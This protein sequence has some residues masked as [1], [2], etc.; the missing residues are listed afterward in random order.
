MPETHL[1]TSPFP[2]IVRKF[3]IAVGVM[4]MSELLL[5]FS[6]LQH[7]MFLNFASSWFDPSL[8]AA[9]LWPPLLFQS[10]KKA[11][12]KKI[13]LPPSPSKLLVIGNL[14]QL[15]SLPH[16]SLYAL[17]KKHTPLTLLQLCQVQTLVVSSPGV[18]RDI[19]KAHGCD[20]CKQAFCK[21]C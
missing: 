11:I 18:A 20:L 8:L 15:D 6:T 4:P 2:S 14:H 10:I 7:K 13:K 19:M 17:S 1:G 12:P 16:R 21:G 9:L 3:E 5:R